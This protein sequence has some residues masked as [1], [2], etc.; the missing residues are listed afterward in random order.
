MIYGAGCSTTSTAAELVTQ[1]AAFVFALE[2]LI[3]QL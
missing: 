1:K 3:W 2:C